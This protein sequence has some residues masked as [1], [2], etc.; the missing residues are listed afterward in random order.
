MTTE[1]V[2]AAQ[3][4]ANLKT[5]LDT[6]ETTHQRYLITRNGHARS[7]LMSLEDLEH[8]EDTLDILSDPEEIKAIEE[9]IAEL[10]RGEGIPLEQVRREMCL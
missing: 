8:L 9:G 1:T 7:I 10:D 3:A 2:S 5:L 6:V 4:R